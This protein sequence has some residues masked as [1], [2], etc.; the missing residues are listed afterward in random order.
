M[1]HIMRKTSFNLFKDNDADQLRR[2]LAA[3]QRLYFC[4]IHC[5]DSTISL[6]PKS[7]ITSL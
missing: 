2:N 1:S 6:L 4:Y 5:V 3:N 7:G